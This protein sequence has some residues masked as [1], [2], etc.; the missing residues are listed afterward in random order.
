MLTNAL[1]G[2]VADV[3]RASRAAGA[4]V[5][6]YT[7]HGGANQRW[8]LGTVQD[9]YL[10]ITAGHSGLCLAGSRSYATQ[11]A[12]DPDAGNQLWKV[13]QVQGGIRLSTRS[14]PSRALGI[15]SY[16]ADGARVLALRRPSSSPTS[17]TW[18]VTQL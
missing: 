9:G 18:T 6:Q 17:T 5:V 1:T 13:T 12:C 16:T 4:P 7:A 10:S 14:S 8:K 11:Q 3:V 2:L 15:G